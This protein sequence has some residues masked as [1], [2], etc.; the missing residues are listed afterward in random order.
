MQRIVLSISWGLALTA[1]AVLL[2]LTQ[3]GER[4]AEKLYGAGFALC[5]PVA[6]GRLFGLKDKRWT[7]PWLL[8]CGFLVL[9]G[10]LWRFLL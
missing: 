5:G 7:V 10:L 9:A 2:V 8:L 4:P 1:A 3:V 6:L